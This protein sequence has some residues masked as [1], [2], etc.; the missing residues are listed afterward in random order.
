VS[1][2]PL[3]CRL[4]NEYIGGIQHEKQIHDERDV[5]ICDGRKLIAA[6]FVILRERVSCGRGSWK[7]ICP[8]YRLETPGSICAG[9]H[10]C[11]CD[12][13]TSAFIRIF[14]VPAGKV[15]YLNVHVKGTYMK[16]VIL[17]LDDSICQ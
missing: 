13:F 12:A 14:P 3:S 6:L 2:K 15:L 9:S 17:P 5:C 16:F 4:E 1:T 11:L 7:T 8:S 10:G